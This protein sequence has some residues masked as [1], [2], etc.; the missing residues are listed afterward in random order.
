MI[1][2][3]PL[4]KSAAHAWTFVK[5]Q[6]NQAMQQLSLDALADAGLN[7][8]DG[9]RVDLEAGVYV[10]EVLAHYF[11]ATLGMITNIGNA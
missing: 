1:E 10:R 7:P 3:K 2:T 8:A 6:A 4:L 11:P 9:W 5:Q